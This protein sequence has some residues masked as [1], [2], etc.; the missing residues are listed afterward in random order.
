M[1]NQE[2][3][4]QWAGSY[5]DVVN[6]TR[7]M[8]LKAKKLMLE[9]ISFSNVLELGCGT[10]K[11]TEWLAQ[12]ANR[13]TAVD[14]SEN[15][16][17]KARERVKADNVEFKQADI[18]S[19]WD[20][21]TGPVGLITCSLVLEHIEHLKPVFKKASELLVQNGHFYIGELH[22]FKQYAGSKARF[23]KNEETIVLDC[24]TH[25]ISEFISIALGKG[26]EVEQVTEYFDDP[27]DKQI[28]R[29]LGLMFRKK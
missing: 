9:N 6:L 7:D 17:A 19:A 4:N 5:N 14:F 24:F 13:V 22:P 23:E 11:N 29:I 28:P 12:K 21:A 15:M 27:E 16:L 25:H 20:F 8:E 18:N 10:G 2:A 3:Y 26:F 1:N